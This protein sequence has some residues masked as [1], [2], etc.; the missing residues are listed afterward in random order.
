[1]LL[2]IRPL[3]SCSPEFR[4]VFITLILLTVGDIKSNLGPRR[5]DSYYNFSVCRWNLNSITAHNFEKINLPEAYHT[6]NRFDVICLSESYLY[7]SIASDNDDLN[8]KV[9]SLYRADHPNNAKRCGAC[10]YITE[11]LPVRC[12]SNTYLQECLML[13]ISINNKKGYVVSLYPLVKLQMNLTPS[14]ALSYTGFFE[15]QKHGR[16][17]FCPPILTFVLEQQ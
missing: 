11:S 8:I 6:I 15:L 7:S 2:T 9:Y 14:L 4:F 13:E 3:F 1:M 10:A 16:E 17:A 5:R 12:L